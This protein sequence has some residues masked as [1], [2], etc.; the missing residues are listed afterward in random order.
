MASPERP[1]SSVLNEIMGNLQGL[2]RSEARLAKTELKEDLRK[3]SAG[4]AWVG[5]GLVMLAFSGLFVLVAAVS[6]LSEV[7]PVWAA[8]LIVAAGEGLIAAL[9]VAVGMRRF[10]ALRAAPKTRE[11]LK[12]NMEWAKHPS[13]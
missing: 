2:V 6:A 13:R 4:A 11:T 5:A 10:K 12:E 7:M 8:A 1:I 9:C 3:T